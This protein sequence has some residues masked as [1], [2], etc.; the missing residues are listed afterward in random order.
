MATT[1]PLQSPVLQL[2]T[3][4]FHSFEPPVN[5][6]G[7]L[8][9][10]TPA[11]Y[12]FLDL[13]AWIL[14]MDKPPPSSASSSSSS[15]S[16]QE[17]AHRTCST[18]KHRISNVKF[19]R[20]S[21]CIT[22]RSVKCDM[23]NRCD[24]CKN[25]T[26]DE[27]A[28][29]L[30]HRKSLDAKKKKES[31]DSPATPSSSKQL[32]TESTK[33]IE[34]KISESMKSLFGSLVEKLDDIITDKVNR[35]ISAPL[36]VPEPAPE[37]G[38]GGDVHRQRVKEPQMIRTSGVVPLSSMDPPHSQYNTT[39]TSTIL[40]SSSVVTSHGS[41]QFCDSGSLGLRMNVGEGVN[42]DLDNVNV[43]DP[44]SFLFAPFSVSS[45]VSS[46]SQLRPP[47]SSSF[48]VASLS[49]PASI[50]PSS[51]RIS[52]S[53]T[54]SFLPPSSL[55][56]PSSLPD[57]SVDKYALADY[58]AGVLGLS[59]AYQRLSRGYF[60]ANLSFAKFSQMI[61][62]NRPELMRDLL[63]DCEGG[64]SIY[65]DSLKSGGVVPSGSSDRVSV[66]SSLA[67]FGFVSHAVD[68][69]AGSGS[70]VVSVVSSSQRPLPFSLTPIPP[71][72]SAVASFPSDFSSSF[73]QAPPPSSLPSSVFTPF[74]PL[75]LP[76]APVPARLMSSVVS[77]SVVDGGVSVLDS[78]ASAVRSSASAL[79]NIVPPNVGLGSS[80]FSIPSLLSSSRLAS[81]SV[82]Q[83]VAS[84]PPPPVASQVGGS[85]ARSDVSGEAVFQDQ[86]PDPVQS[87]RMYRMMI[88]FIVQLFPQAKGDSGSNSDLR[89]LFE[90]FYSVPSSSLP[91]IPKLNWFDRV[92]SALKEA[93][94]RLA[95]AVEDKRT[96][97]SLLP[98]Y[99]TLYSVS[100][101]VS[102]SRYLPLNELL[103]SALTKVPQTSRMANISIKDLFSLEAAFRAQVESLSHSMWVLTA[104]IAFLKRDGYAPSD[105]H[106]F[107]QL[108]SSLSMGL[109]HLANSS[110]SCTSFVVTKRRE[111]YLAFLP[112]V[113]SDVS[114]RSLL[115]APANI[116]SKLF[117]DSDVISA[118]EASN[119]ASSLQSQQA[120]VDV[121]SRGRVSPSRGRSPSRSP[122]SGRSRQS[123]SGS[124]P[125][126]VRFSDAK[127]PPPS[128]MKR[129]DFAK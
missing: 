11:P 58:N 93:D 43:S 82:P 24:E 112:P 122:R 38:A 91:P 7:S 8:S 26:E 4:Q 54:S 98:P 81:S 35:S 66:S 60:I 100:D 96:G 12:L 107:N 123:S 104:L 3:P 115:R 22:C 48:S 61:F 113:F 71:S 57:H 42:A 53:S 118:R 2:P 73:P 72:S 9:L 127:S 89:S 10:I 68:G 20:H 46:S 28:S 88:D 125:K 67:G 52:V 40:G 45:P 95:S 65:W 47:I 70:A 119:L 13:S 108:V 84:A 19:D 51:S 1:S 92:S 56:S 50:P 111:C 86:A 90:S 102:R 109:S 34:S 94:V 18:C 15:A 99:K 85:P 59:G 27:M 16:T 25:W 74:P 114:K 116:A 39:Q 78:G 31:K 110:A 87:T 37:G 120:L 121:A 5:I 117:S 103:E 6:T 44:S 80:A 30:K 33:F 128:S 49:V 79:P 32:D 106:L 105:P 23:S 97:V 69:L 64:P 75:S 63:K 83:G 77:P 124:S 101:N 21:V 129:K 126:R 17:I 36:V 14:I 62:S 29:Y 41:N 76:S 55:A